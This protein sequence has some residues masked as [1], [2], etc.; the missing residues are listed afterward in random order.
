MTHCACLLLALLL[1]TCA[2]LGGKEKNLKNHRPQRHD[3][4]NYFP[5]SHPF[6]PGVEIQL[7]Y[8]VHELGTSCWLWLPLAVVLQSSASEWKARPLRC[9]KAHTPALTV[10]L[11]NLRG[12]QRV[13][14]ALDSGPCSCDTLTSLTLKWAANEDALHPR[15]YECTLQESKCH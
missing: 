6:L 2:S 8:G 12:Y 4:L 1:V 7:A 10:E 9:I 14:K 13:A 3:N 5:S 15:L 11:P